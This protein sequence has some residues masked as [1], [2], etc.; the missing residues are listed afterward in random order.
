MESF[1]LSGNLTDVVNRRIFPATLTIYGGV[2]EN[3]TEEKNPYS[4]YIVPGFTDAHIHIE[5]SMLLP[6]EFAR[7]ALKHG[8]V[9]TV[10]D[11][12]EIANVC[13]IQGVYYMIENA[14]GAKLKFN[15]GAP[16]CVPATSFETAGAV[17][18]AQHINELLKRTDIKYLSEMM[19]YPGVLNGDKEV[20]GKINTA[21]KYNKPVDGHAPGLRG[22]IAAKYIAAGIS[23]DHEC[24]TLDEALDKLKYGMKIIIREG[25]AAKNFDA[26]HSLI[27]THTKSVMLCSDDKHPDDLLE[28]HI[29]LLVVRALKKGHAIFDVLQCA[30]L[31]P[32]NHYGLD[33]GLLQMGDKADFIV[34]NNL[35]N[36][37]VEK[38]YINGEC[39][40]E[41]SKTFLPVKKHYVINNFDCS[42]IKAVDLKIKSTSEKIKIIEALDG[43][44][45]THCIIDSVKSINGFLQCDI[46]KDYLKIAVVNRYK[47]APPAVG[48]IKNFGFKKGAIA[49]SVAHDS[50][51]IIAVG[52]TDNDIANAINIII[53]NKGG[54]SACDENRGYSIALPVAGLMSDK[55]CEEIGNAYKNIDAFAKELGS[56]LRSPYMTL[57]FMAL[58]VIPHFKIGD[59]G[60]FNVD[61]FGFEEIGNQI[62]AGNV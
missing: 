56:K 57:S 19:N 27:S 10:S 40:A 17:L 11:P 31:N 43:Q 13:G 33:V 14:K 4:N 22:E 45:I 26:L 34:V 2:I 44:L 15:F 41:N 39:V 60:L 8:T 24:F 52:T 62:V 53:K 1:T 38:T 29:N 6:Y 5:S 47:N 46:G 61:H 23:T 30:C 58:L 32:V 20:L 3:I 54:L 55:S 12:H 28:G 21:H 7:T 51:N 18:D 25:S 9:A 59:K 37:S 16:S 49:S 50:H 48:F 36:F 35:D 42:N